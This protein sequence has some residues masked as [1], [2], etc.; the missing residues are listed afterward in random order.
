VCI[1]KIKKTFRFVRKRNIAKIVLK[2]KPCL[3][4]GEGEWGVMYTKKLACEDDL[5]TVMLTSFFLPADP[6][7][8]PNLCFDLIKWVL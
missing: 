8:Q 3:L 1:Y 4:L 5:Y 7:S 6:K 2:I